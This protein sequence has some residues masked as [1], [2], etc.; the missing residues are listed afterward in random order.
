[1]TKKERGKKKKRLLQCNAG[2]IA[3]GINIFS[4]DVCS[5]IAAGILQTIPWLA[6]YCDILC[7]INSK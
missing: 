4:L 1:M 5:C 7:V 6:L 3:I 2:N